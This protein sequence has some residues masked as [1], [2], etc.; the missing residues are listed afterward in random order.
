MLPVHSA[1]RLVAITNAAVADAALPSETRQTVIFSP[2]ATEPYSVSNALQGAFGQGI[3]VMPNGG[4]VILRRADI[5]DAV[6]HRWGAISQ[7]N[8][9]TDAVLEAFEERPTTSK[10][11][12]QDLQFAAQSVA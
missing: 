7:T 4:P 1:I 3:V 8:A 11:E 6:C 9:V 10:S 12:L 5:G 2:H